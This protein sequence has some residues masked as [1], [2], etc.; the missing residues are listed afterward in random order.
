MWLQRGAC[1]VLTCWFVSVCVHIPTTHKHTT[2]IHTYIYTQGIRYI[3]GKA[4]WVGENSVR[5]E[6]TDGANVTEIEFD[7]AV[8]GTGSDYSNLKVCDNM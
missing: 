2:H 6:D 8:I 1:A 3:E 7:Y 5:I 4:T